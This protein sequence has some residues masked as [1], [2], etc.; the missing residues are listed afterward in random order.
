VPSR[1]GR[2]LYF[3]LAL[4]LLAASAVDAQTARAIADATFRSVVLITMEDGNGR[5]V[6]TASGFFVREDLVATNFH[7]IVAGVRG[8]VKLVG[9][10]AAYSIA[11]L[12]GMDEAKDLAVLKVLGVKAPSLR[13]GSDADA[14][15]GDKIYVVGNPLGLEGTFS[16]G[17]ISGI[18]R[19][20]SRRLLQI[21]APISPG[22]SGGPVLNDTGQAIGIAVA[23]LAEGQNLNFAVPISDLGPLLAQPARLSPLPGKTRLARA[24]AAADVL[25]IHEGL[26][27]C[28]G[29]CTSYS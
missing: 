28:L 7:V 5:R 15:V 12:V 3:A 13:L 14:R 11:G 19:D 2:T 25:Q 21:T 9:A 16:D 18:R 27:R 26:P 22:S 4:P 24:A 10:T 8:H 17:L 29:S 20:G 6:A 23:T 1:P